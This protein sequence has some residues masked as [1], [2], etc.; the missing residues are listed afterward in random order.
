VNALVLLVGLDTR[1][2]QFASTMSILEDQLDAL[3]A[4]GEIEVAADAALSLVDAAKNPELDPEQKRRLEDAVRRFA[5]PD[6][7]RAIVKALRQ[8]K[9]GEPTH[10]AARRLLDAM[11]AI[12][13]PPLLEQ[14]ADEPDR[15]ERKALIDLLSQDAGKY[16]NELGEQVSDPRWFFVRN[17]IGILASTKSSAILPYL[18]RT[19]R[20]PDSRVRRETIRALSNVGDRR[21]LEMLIQA[22]SD[23]DAQN[24][25]LAARYL[26]MRS[27]QT[28]IPALESV[29]R[30]DGR[31]NRENG[32]RIEAIE[33]LGRLGAI[34]ALPTLTALANKRS[35]LGRAS[36][37]EIK[38]A[39]ASAIKVIERKGGAS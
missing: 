28:A 39:A 16:I 33:A 9:P 6:D 10:D 35:I 27:L 20:Q 37:R 38:T 23:E 1:D 29:A 31:G 34:E 11:G 8:S 14:L 3:V 25:Q 2:A 19:L 17:V 18:E 26:G 22:L 30:G 7:I 15:M 13:Y 32:P 4:N 12:A 24:V 5:R 21:A 36:V